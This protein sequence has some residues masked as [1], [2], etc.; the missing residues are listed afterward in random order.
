MTKRNVIPA[1]AGIQPIT[2][3]FWTL[4]F[5]EVAITIDPRQ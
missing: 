1:Q 5:A 4:A 3:V 2:G